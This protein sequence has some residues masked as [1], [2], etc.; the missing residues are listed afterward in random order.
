MSDHLIQRYLSGSATADELQE[1]ERLLRTDRAFARSLVEFAGMDAAL[2]EILAVETELIRLRRRRPVSQFVAPLVPWIAAAALLIVVIGG[3]YALAPKK[4]PSVAVEPTPPPIVQPPRPAEPPRRP[5][6]AP[7]PERIPEPT[8]PAA[9]EFRPPEIPPAPEPPAPE[10]PPAPKKVES[11]VAVAEIETCSGDVTVDARP[12]AP[13]LAVRS[14]QNVATGRKSSA[15]LTLGN[16]TRLRLGTHTTLVKLGDVIELRSGTLSL[17]VKKPLAVRTPSSTIAVLGTRFNV[18]VRPEGTQVA[19]EEGRVRLSNLEGRSIEL[20]A[21]TFASSADLHTYRE[22]PRIVEDHEKSMAW[23]FC[24]W[25]APAEWILSTDRPYRG[26]GSFRLAYEPRP[27]DPRPYC[28]FRLPIKL[29]RAHRVLRFYMRAAEGE[30]DSQWWVQ[31][32]DKDN[33]V[34]NVGAGKLSELDEGWNK[35]S[36]PILAEPKLAWKGGDG[37][38]DPDAVQHLYFSLANAKGT[39]FTDDWTLLE[40]VPGDK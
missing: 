3:G 15:V 40:I 20:S 10:P 8:P 27:T 21:G 24:D 14:D 12:A 11:A 28:Q 19:V 9:E 34:W 30:K 39:V 13:G 4:S 31:L 17:D 16:G 1:V 32:Q 5:S 23:S 18:A 26:N 35:M 38:Y 2:K 22:V 7:E 6:I 37:T 33:D 29:D 25:G 36:L